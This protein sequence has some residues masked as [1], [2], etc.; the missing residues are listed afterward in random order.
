MSDMRGMKALLT[1]KFLL[2]NLC[3]LLVF[4]PSMAYADISVSMRLDRKEATLVDSVNVVVSVSGTRSSDLLPLLK[5]L[6]AFHV[7]RG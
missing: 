2:L 6:E 7:T 3:C 4:C 5:G 1:R